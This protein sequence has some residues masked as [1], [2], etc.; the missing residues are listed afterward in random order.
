MLELIN[1]YPHGFVAVP[2]VLACKDKGFFHPLKIKKEGPQT[3]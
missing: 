1:R 3:L 2:E